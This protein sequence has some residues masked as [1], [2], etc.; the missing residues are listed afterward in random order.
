MKNFR[1]FFSFCCLSLLVGCVSTSGPAPDPSLLRIGVTPDTPPLIF[2]QG[3][4][5]TGVEAEFGRKLAAEL[6]RKPVFVE[7]K[8]EHLL[9]ALEADRIDIVMS[10]MSVTRARSFRVLF[11]QSYMTAGQ[12]PLFRRNDFSPA[13]LIPSVV[14][15]QTSKIGCVRDTTGSIYTRN[16]YIHAEVIEFSDWAK[17]VKGLLDGKVNMVLHDAPAVWWAASR[18]EEQLVAFPELLN[19][20]DIAW[21]I[22]KNNPELLAQVNGVLQKWRE[23]GEG[24]EILKRWFPGM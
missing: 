5:L 6:E 3:G 8:W 10:G 13:G 7:L 16:A 17:A 9:E 4:K 22:A 2:E 11:T 23:S 21:A 12:T 1:T 20:E 14:R 24:V 19:R 15:H 18:N